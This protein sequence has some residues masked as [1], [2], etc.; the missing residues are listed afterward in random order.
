MTAAN[1]IKQKLKAD[2]TS[3]MK[4]KDKTRVEIFR[5][6]LSKIKQKEIDKRIELSDEQTVQILRELSKQRQQSIKEFKQAGR[7]DLVKKEQFELEILSVYL[8]G[9][10]DE[11]KL[12]EII[13]QVIQETGAKSA[14]DM[15]QVMKKLK[16]KLGNQVDFSIVSQKVKELL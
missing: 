10:I 4:A 13:Q 7:D 6:I 14:R 3:A 1:E 2:L 8:P 9:A 11:S 5:F 15:G 16:E 12:D